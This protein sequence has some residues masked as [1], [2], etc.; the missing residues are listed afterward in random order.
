[1]VCVVSR[2]VHEHMLP[3]IVIGGPRDGPG[4]VGYYHELRI[5]ESTIRESEPESEKRSE[6]QPLRL[7]RRVRIASLTSR[8]VEFVSIDETATAFPSGGWI[9]RR[10]LSAEIPLHGPSALQAQQKAKQEAVKRAQEAGKRSAIDF[11]AGKYRDDAGSGSGSGGR[12]EKDWATG[13]DRDRERDRERSRQGE[14]GGEGG[15][16]RTRTRDD[17]PRDREKRYRKDEGRYRDERGNAGR[18]E[19][20]RTGSGSRY[21]RPRERR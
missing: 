13:A 16:G 6:P 3:S 7:A 8:Q 21:D 19:E 18:Y 1:V 5:H 20:G 15:K 4:D 10:G 11:K 17:E 9:T 14:R 2:G 12:R